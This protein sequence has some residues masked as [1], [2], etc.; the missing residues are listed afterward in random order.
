Y[1][2][3]RSIEIGFKRKKPTFLKVGFFSVL[4]IHV[5]PMYIYFTNYILKVQDF[6]IREYSF[7]ILFT[8]IAIDLLILRMNCST[9]LHQTLVKSCS[10]TVYRDHPYDRERFFLLR[11]S[12]FLKHV[13]AWIYR[14]VYLVY[15]REVHLLQLLHSMDRSRLF[16]HSPKQSS[17]IILQ[18]LLPYLRNILHDVRFYYEHAL[19]PYLLRLSHFS[20][21]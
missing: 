16:P 11:I 5:C 1:I 17:I 9:Y 21:L 10:T 4:V 12:P 7:H 15:P 20:Y 13:L 18:E 14:R 6:A 2:N 8:F 19:H 3:A